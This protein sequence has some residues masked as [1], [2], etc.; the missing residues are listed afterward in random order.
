MKL[1]N[2]KYINM[3]IEK[4]TPNCMVYGESRSVPLSVY[5]SKYDWFGVTR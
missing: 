2:Y 4:Y 1:L 3:K 5:K